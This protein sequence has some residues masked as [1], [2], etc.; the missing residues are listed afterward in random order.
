MND[1]L[2]YFSKVYDGDNYLIYKALKQNKKIDKEELEVF[3][4]KLNL[5]NIQYVTIFDDNYPKSLKNY[6]YSPYVLYYQGNLDLVNNMLV[7][8]T[9]DIANNIVDDNM[10]NSYQALMQNTL[11]TSD[12]KN[13]EQNLIAEYRKNHK[14]IVHLLAYGHDYFKKI[15][16]LD[17]ELYIS[18]Y[19]PE[20]HPKLWRFKERNIL[21]SYL[22]QALIIYSSKKYSGILNLASAFA[23]NNK[24]VYCYPGLDYEDGN[25]Y[26]IKLGAN[27]ITHIGEINYY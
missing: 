19:P 26:L 9:G 7:C 8:A 10:N 4:Q 23:N 27:M 21:L 11:I 15:I 16:N 24:E 22:A 14:A 25:S 6:K 1:I 2:L 3:K 17:N 18:Q 13:L 20:V 12:Y 5:K